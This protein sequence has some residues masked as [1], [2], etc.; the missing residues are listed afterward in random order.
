M[1]SNNSPITHT[2]EEALKPE[3]RG[4]IVRHLQLIEK[5]T[6]RFYPQS[7]TL[8]SVWMPSEGREG[9]IAPIQPSQKIRRLEALHGEANDIVGRL[10]T[11]WLGR[12]YI[13]YL[14]QY[15][16]IRWFAHWIWRNGYPFYVNH[17]ASRL[18]GS[19]ARRWRSL[20]KLSQFAKKNELPIYKLAD[21]TLVETPEPKVFPACDKGYLESPHGR[22]RFPEI[23]VATINNAITYGGTNLILSGGEVVCHDLY[24]FERDFTSEELHGRT[25]IDP[26]SRRIRWLLH[27]EA[28][29]PIPVAATFVDACASNYAHWMTEVLPRIVLFCAEDRFLGVPI[30][31]NDGLHKNIMESLFLVAGTKREIITLPVGRALAVNELY[32]TSVTGYVPFGRRTNKLSGHSHG[33]FST[34]SFE[35]LRNHV[36]GLDGKT[37]LEAW[38]EKIYLRRNSGARKVTNA[39]EIEKLLISKGY[40]VVEPERL[41]F[42]H[43]IQ[44][45]NHAKEIVSPTGAALANAIA[46][47]PGAQ[48]AI[49]MSKHQDMIYGYWSNLLS[50]FGIKVNYV[51]GNI[52]ENRDLGIHGDFAIDADCINEMLEGF[53][54]K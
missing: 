17:I 21:A 28:P 50:P 30:V 24:D 7:D 23:Y 6:A 16:V 2:R 5:L 47:M 36:S 41:T 49:L 46:C 29:E 34:R 39:P 31:V 20:I 33:L 27:D 44:L 25:L 37:E 38:P 8:I 40:V 42:L 45:F 12:L 54:Q 48:V 4:D 18:S 19:R 3:L 35:L 14:K 32:L 9:V 22:Y 52:I 26:K 13:S 15:V 43:Q 11:A 1:D 53:E 10:R 51:L